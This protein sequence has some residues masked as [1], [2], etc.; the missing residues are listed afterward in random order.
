MADTPELGYPCTALLVSKE[1]NRPVPVSAVLV[2]RSPWCQHFITTD[3]SDFS[4]NF[5]HIEAGS[6]FK[7][8][9]GFKKCMSC[10]TQ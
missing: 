10:Y 3:A 5:V 9:I 6:I 7:H 4:F 2:I 1:E 8:F